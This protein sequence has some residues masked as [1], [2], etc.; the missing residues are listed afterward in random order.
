MT[1]SK[2]VGEGTSG[3]LQG[4]RNR[5]PRQECWLNLGGIAGGTISGT[6][7]SKEQCLPRVACSAV[8]RWP[9]WMCSSAAAR[10]AWPLD[11]PAMATTR[12]PVPSRACAMALAAGGVHRA[13]SARAP[14]RSANNTGFH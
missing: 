10:E 2:A 6:T 12:C 11:T 8:P 3:V 14:A 1:H 4:T 9:Q 13:R 5:P 7:Y